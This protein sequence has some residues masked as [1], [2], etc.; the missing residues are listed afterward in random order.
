V[1]ELVEVGEPDVDRLVRRYLAAFGPATV[2]DAQV[3]SGLTRLRA[4][5]ARLELEE[6]DGGYFDLAGAPRP[7]PETPAPVRFLPRYDDLLIGYADRSRFGNVV[8]GEPTILVDG[9]VAGTWR[10]T[11]DDVEVSLSR[12]RPGVEEERSRLRDWLAAEAD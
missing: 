10:W 11:G 3:W 12:A 5:F 7:D 9:L 8:I 2:R 4:V 1:Q 6:L